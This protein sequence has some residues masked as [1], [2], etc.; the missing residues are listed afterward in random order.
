MAIENEFPFIVSIPGMNPEKFNPLSLENFG[1]VNGYQ[2]SEIQEIEQ[3]YLSAGDG[4]T[5][6]FR[7]VTRKTIDGRSVPKFIQTF[8]LAMESENSNKCQ[9]FEETITEETWEAMLRHKNIGR[10]IVKRRFVFVPNMELIATT[11]MAFANPPDRINFLQCVDNVAIDFFKN[12][13]DGLVKIEVEMKDVPLQQYST[14][15]HPFFTKIVGTNRYRVVR[16]NEDYPFDVLFPACIAKHLDV[17]RIIN[18]AGV[19]DLSNAVM[20]TGLLEPVKANIGYLW[21][22]AH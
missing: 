20:A 6:R 9:E 13:F 19:P 5:H 22:S 2:L 21:E 12:E 14:E 18:V 8:K 16:A 7:K 17:N 1:Q 15:N 4:F 3:F 10:N 11:S